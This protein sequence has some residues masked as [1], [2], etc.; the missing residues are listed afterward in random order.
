VHL[1]LEL[2]SKGLVRSPHGRYEEVANACLGPYRNR[3]AEHQPVR[4]AG[5]VSSA[6]SKRDVG[7]TALRADRIG[8][9]YATGE[10]RCRGRGARR[11]PKTE[12]VASLGDGNILVRGTS[13]RTRV[14]L[15]T[16]PAPSGAFFFC[17][18]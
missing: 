7:L 6:G 1:A 11:D 18:V 15:P 5:Q 9:G 14:E 4:A 13:V 16:V 12:L 2:P 17:H 3:S 10:D 8:H